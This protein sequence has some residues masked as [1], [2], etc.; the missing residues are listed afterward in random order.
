M[1]ETKEQPKW[2]KRWWG[3]LLIIGFFYIF[4]PYYVWTKKPYWNMWVKIGITAVCLLIF[5]A[6][7]DRNSTQP[8]YKT[9]SPPK[10]EVS[11]ESKQKAFDLVQ[12]AETFIKENKINEAISAVSESKKV[13]PNK[14]DNTA[15]ALFDRIALLQSAE[16]LKD[17]LIN[18]SD[19][20]Y[21]LLT[22]GS[23]KKS[24]LDHEVLNG[25][26]LGK[27][28]KNSTQRAVFLAE[29]KAQKE[30]ERME[31]EKKAAEEAAAKRTEEIGRQF[32]AWDGS[33]YNLTRVIKESMNDPKSYEH[34]KTSYFDMKD[35]IVVV[36]EFRGS[37]AFGGIVKNTI[38]AKVGLDGNVLEIMDD[39]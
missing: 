7:F 31:A 3:I 33:H 5:I 14:E 26:F 2:Y 28:E 12:Q 24:Y 4:I 29:I 17:T 6:A 23:L 32:S 30:R 34:V 25:L 35:Y 13:N 15:Y 37:N 22:A 21:T 9:P 20:E 1:T 19:E 11:S 18:M 38:R 27:L 16:F 36:T 39:Y 8:T 10:I